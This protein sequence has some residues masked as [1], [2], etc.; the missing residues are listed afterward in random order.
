MILAEHLVI[1]LGVSTSSGTPSSGTGGT[2][3]SVDTGGDGVGDGDGDGD[4]DGA[5]EDDDGGVEDAMTD[6]LLHSAV[7][8][9]DI[10]F[11]TAA[12]N[13]SFRGTADD[14]A[15]RNGEENKDCEDT[16]D[17]GVNVG[18]DHASDHTEFSKN[19]SS[20]SSSSSF[21]A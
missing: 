1:G 8:N 21:N 10:E 6:T 16:G 11:A 18:D 12:V 19:D 15:A 3:S 5:E 4:G 14:N 13:S 2:S 20:S 9:A 17:L 7:G